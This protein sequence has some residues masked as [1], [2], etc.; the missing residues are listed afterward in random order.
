MTF[1]DWGVCEVNLVIVHLM[2]IIETK[3]RA[4]ISFRN[5]QTTDNEE[6]LM[7]CRKT[8]AWLLSGELNHKIHQQ[9]KHE[10]FLYTLS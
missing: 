5:A 10:S 4:H 2:E 8:L 3:S 1:V 9:F 6:S 7:K